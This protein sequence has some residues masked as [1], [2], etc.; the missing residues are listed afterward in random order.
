MKTNNYN[1]YTT[2]FSDENQ[3][4]DTDKY[5]KLS[6]RIREMEV[7]RKK[8]L[9]FYCFLLV[10]MAVL[11]IYGGQEKEGIGLRIIS[12]GFAL[13]AVLLFIRLRMLNNHHFLLPMAQFLAVA[14]KRLQY[15]TA[16]E[17]WFILPI[18]MILGIGGGIHFIY[19]LMH[20][21]Q[22]FWMLLGIW[23]IFYIALCIWGYYAG[24]KQWNKKYG[25]LH[26]DIQKFI[27]ELKD[28][29]ENGN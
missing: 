9:L 29:S 16:S 18:T 22:Q 3:E 17:F 5:N 4:M 1:K 8:E 20:Y 6:E 23:V 21:T 15:L 7:Q 26:Q 24:R 11:Y 19:R 13:G 2:K 10:F 12:I 28:E 27:I 25:K 14:G